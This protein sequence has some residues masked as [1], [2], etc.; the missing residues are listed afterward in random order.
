LKKKNKD[1]KFPSIDDGLKG[2]KFIFAAKKSSQNNGK[3]IKL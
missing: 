2:I 3:W 1:I